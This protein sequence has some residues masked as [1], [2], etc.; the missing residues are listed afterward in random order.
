MQLAQAIQNAQFDHVLSRYSAI[1]THKCPVK[2]RLKR[3][4]KFHPFLVTF[5]DTESSQE[6]FTYAR[7]YAFESTVSIKWTERH[8]ERGWPVQAAVLKQWLTDRLNMPLPATIKAQH[9]FLSCP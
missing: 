4:R 2:I 7:V 9:A 1:L 3:P 8:A 6:C 5:I